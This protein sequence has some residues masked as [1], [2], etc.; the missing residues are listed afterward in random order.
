MFSVTIFFVCTSYITGKETE[1]NRLSGESNIIHVKDSRC[2]TPQMFGAKG[3]GKHDDTEAILKAC[4]SD[5]DTLFFPKGTYIINIKEG[6]DRTKDKDFFRTNIENIIGESRLSTIIKLGKGNGDAANG[7]G[8]A[9]IFS[10]GGKDSH[11]HIKNLTF[12]FNYPE[13]PITQYT[14]N[15]VGVEHNG[16]QMAINAYRTSSL[17]VENCM[18]LDHSGTNCIDHRANAESDTLYCVIRNCEFQNIGKPSLYKTKEAY[19]DCSTLALHCDSRKQKSKYVCYVEHNIFEGAGGNAFDACECSADEFT[20][21]NNIISGYVVGVMPLT[22]NPGTIA[23]IEC[24]RFDGIARGVGI[25]SNDNDIKQPNGSL[26]FDEIIIKNNYIRIDIEKYIRRP[27]FATIEKKKGDIYPGGFY[28]A[29]CC[30]GLWTKTL[31]KLHVKD[32]F[33]MYD[34]LLKTSNQDFTNGVNK[35]NGAVLG[36]Y[37]LFDRSVDDTYCKEI[38]FNDNVIRNPVTTILRIVPFN[39]IGKLSFSYNTITECWQNSKIE[40]IN[41]GLIS[42][43]PACYGKEDRLSWGDFIIEGNNIEYDYEASDYATAFLSL[44]NKKNRN[45]ESS[46]KVR[47]NDIRKPRYGLIKNDIYSFFKKVDMQ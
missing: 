30:M 10:F 45:A 38:I 46:I 29:I 24:N 14:S 39:E 44:P 15:H 27:Q 4:Q 33:I 28:G 12:D 6:K 42:I 36:L 2:V 13:N 37:N 32:N 34:K 17:V 35:Y 16:Q 23:Q 8:F 40:L 5:A 31:N 43:H 18:F 20:F 19:H 26:G 3:D 21:K 41:D 11:P 22:T 47:G 1:E 25:W 9:S 7:K